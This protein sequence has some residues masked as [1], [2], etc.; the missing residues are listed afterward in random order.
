MVSKRSNIVI[1][2]FCMGLSICF[3][4]CDSHKP[5]LPDLQ[6]GVIAQ[7]DTNQY[8]NIQWKDTLLDF[9]T[10][11]E[12]DSVR[13]GFSFMNTGQKPL[14]INEVRPTCGCTIADY[15]LKPLPP[16]ASGTI[17]VV[18]G[19]DWHP[20]SQRKI[21]LVRANTR[22]RTMHKLVFAGEVVPKPKPTKS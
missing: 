14:F 11:H 5:S 7:L 18:F 8:T 16:G 22:V 3:S 21:I 1:S 9:G 20:G 2:V 6:P 15:P 13:L 4:A 19:T 17:K 12:G 10:V